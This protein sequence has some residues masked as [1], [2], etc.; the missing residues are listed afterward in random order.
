MSDDWYYAEG[1]ESKGPM[2]L[3][4]LTGILK[5]KARPLD[6]WV[7]QPEFSE[8]VSAGSLPELNKHLRPPPLPGQAEA[9]L[10]SDR[11]WVGRGNRYSAETKLYE[12]VKAAE[13]EAKV[14]RLELAERSLVEQDHY[15]EALRRRLVERYDVALQAADQAGID[16]YMVAAEELHNKWIARNAALVAVRAEY[17]VLRRNRPRRPRRTLGQLLGFK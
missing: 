4:E 5:R 12:Y 9:P 6:V 2:S 13:Y 14:D 16:G 10:I 1:E 11:A 17:E 3:V 15:D 8:W 7:W